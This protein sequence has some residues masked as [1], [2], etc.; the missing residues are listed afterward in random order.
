M[1]PTNGKPRLRAHYEENVRP[2]LTEVFGFGNPHEIPRLEKIVVNAGIG[3]G[4]DN[5]KL[6]E[7]AANELAVITGQKPVITNARRSIS[8]FGLR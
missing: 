6:I 1:S 3:E 8:N 2:K 5:P 4:K 7:S